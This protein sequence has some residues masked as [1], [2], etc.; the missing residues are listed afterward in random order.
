M[1]V[2]FIFEGGTPSANSVQNPDATYNTAGSYYVALY[3]KN[4]DGSDIAMKLDYLN[5]IAASEDWST[6]TTKSN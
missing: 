6:E 5:F 4:A 1:V 3:S 2:N